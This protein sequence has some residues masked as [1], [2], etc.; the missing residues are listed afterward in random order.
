MRGIM[1][2]WTCGW[3]GIRVNWKENKIQEKW[4]LDKIKYEAKKGEWFNDGTMISNMYNST[5][6]TTVLLNQEGEGDYFYWFN[7]TYK[8]LKFNFP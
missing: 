5:N 2:G 7:P 3:K 4:N 1:D 8:S 6:A